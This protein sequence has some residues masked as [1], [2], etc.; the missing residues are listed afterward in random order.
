MSNLASFLERVRA[1]ADQDLPEEGHLRRRLG[2][3][4]LHDVLSLDRILNPQRAEEP[5]TPEC[6]RHEAEGC[7]Q[8]LLEMLNRATHDWVLYRESPVPLQRRRAEDAEVWLFLEGP[9]H[10]NWKL[11]KAEG[12]E[13]TSFLS[14]CEF[15]GLEPSAVR[16]RVRTLTP[17]TLQYAGRM[18]DPRNPAPSAGPLE[19]H[20]SLSLSVLEAALANCDYSDI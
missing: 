6:A 19:V 8:I 16:A 15:L 17:D 5:P 10:P 1:A 7:R 9:G 11:R 20:L 14:V 4:L 12:K 13:L 18:G 3:A 2:I